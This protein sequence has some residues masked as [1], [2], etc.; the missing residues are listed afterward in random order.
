[1]TSTG[2]PVKYLGIPGSDQMLFREIPGAGQ[3]SSTDV[4][5]SD[6]VDQS[7]LVHVD[8]SEQNG[9]SEIEEINNQSAGGL[10][11]S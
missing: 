11:Q 6:P 7:D 8:H 5:S 10:Q 1:M 9:N 4:V 2:A 3:M